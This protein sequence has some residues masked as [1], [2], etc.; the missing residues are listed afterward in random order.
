MEVSGPKKRG[1]FNL[2][3]GRIFYGSPSQITVVQHTVTAIWVWTGVP[4]AFVAAENLMKPCY[5]AP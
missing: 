2:Q 4:A 3:Q 5:R 1:H